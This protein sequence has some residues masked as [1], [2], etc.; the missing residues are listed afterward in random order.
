MNT[1]VPLLE[2]AAFQDAVEQAKGLAIL[3]EHQCLGLGHLILGLER[4]RR[5]AE[6]RQFEGTLEWLPAL[7][8]SH[9]SEFGISIED[10]W[11]PSSAK[12][13]LGPE[14]RE[15]IAKARDTG[16]PGLLNL[17]RPLQQG[18]GLQQDPTYLATLH[19]AY[20]VAATNGET[21]LT[22]ELL[23]AG[24]SLAHRTGAFS[25]RPAVDR[26]ISGSATSV[27][28]LLTRRGW[29][30][31]EEIRT[32][33]MDAFPTDES[34]GKAL[35]DSAGHP[36]PL[37]MVINSALRAAHVFDARGR[38]AYH[39]A[40]HAIASLVLR[41][42]A[43]IADISLEPNGTDG[44][45]KIDPSSNIS[46]PEWS[47]EDYLEYLECTLAGRAAERRYAGTLDGH[48]EGAEKDLENA[49]LHAWRCITRY[50]FDDEIGPVHVASLMEKAGVAGGYLIEQ[51]QI[52]LQQV[53]R[54]AESR[55][56]L[57]IEQHWP[58]IETLAQ[59]LIE[60]GS[61]TYD[62]IIEKVGLPDPGNP[63]FHQPVSSE[64]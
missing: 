55:V 63:A 19:A 3:L 2:D 53:L 33:W 34:L 7:A 50:G 23:T 30:L 27:L 36:D 38:T 11:Q 48:N 4:V 24:A 62:E 10:D 21:K 39:E 43:V 49:T 26:V 44:V 14:L 60:S 35:S 13:R 16:L 8:V 15:L 37:L 51:A 9:A 22:L 28:R 5:V 40:G 54:E 41:P 58:S 59:A 45:V 52:R 32:D 25:V 42:E 47:R 46:G 18:P 64:L 1:I 31:P 6:S 20:T 57:L 61:L 29:A 17:L 12:K 56:E